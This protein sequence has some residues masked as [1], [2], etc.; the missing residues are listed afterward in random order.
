[1]VIPEEQI[2]QTVDGTDDW[3]WQVVGS[4]RWV[5]GVFTTDSKRMIMRL[6]VMLAIGGSCEEKGT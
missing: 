5:V 6:N 3:V 2:N 1:M 4:G